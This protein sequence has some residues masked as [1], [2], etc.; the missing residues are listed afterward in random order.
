MQDERLERPGRGSFR[1][2]RGD[3]CE[4]QRLAGGGR[5]SVLLPGESLPSQETTGNSALE[6]LRHSDTVVAVK[7]ILY[8]FNLP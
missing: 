7:K 5:G 6:S 1:W 2:G 3:L 4:G 8:I